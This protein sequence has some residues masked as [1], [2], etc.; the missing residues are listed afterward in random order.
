MDVDISIS[1]ELLILLDW[2]INNDKNSLDNIVKNAVGNGLSQK[3]NLKVDINNPDLLEQFYPTIID[4]LL[5]LENSLVESLAEEQQQALNSREILP[6]L[7]KLSLKDINLETLYLSTK[8]ANK[9]LKNHKHTT[10]NTQKILF[11]QI[12]KNW[13]PNKGSLQN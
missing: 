8:Q 3:L 9:K 5:M 12:L 10:E 4:F 2:L 13:K 7:R 1:L 6:V 11:E